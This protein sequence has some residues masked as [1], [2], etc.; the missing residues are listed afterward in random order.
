VVGRHKRRLL[1]EEEPE[2]ALHETPA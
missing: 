2:E 1:A